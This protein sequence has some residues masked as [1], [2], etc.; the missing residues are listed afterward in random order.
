MVVRAAYCLRLGG[1]PHT[2]LNAGTPR[3]APTPTPTES[4]SLQ[5]NGVEGK[6]CAALGA[7]RQHR[8][9][10]SHLSSEGAGTWPLAGQWDST[11]LLRWD[12]FT[13]WR[14]EGPTA[15]ATPAS[16]HEA[17]HGWESLRSFRFIRVCP[18]VKSAGMTSSV[19]CHEL[20]FGPSRHCGAS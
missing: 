3:E 4:T 11:W 16:C 10:T 14:N 18:V 8:D 17:R 13:Q 15:T 19:P 6:N 7:P 5:N 1:R 12:V 20:E 9:S 2:H